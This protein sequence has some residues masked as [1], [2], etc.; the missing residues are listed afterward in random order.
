MLVQSSCNGDEVAEFLGHT[1]A[2]RPSLRLR[3]VLCDR[4]DNLPA[5]L[6]TLVTPAVGDFSH[7]MMNFVKRIF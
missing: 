3:N 6:R 1:L 2:Q 7:A 5:R 4:G